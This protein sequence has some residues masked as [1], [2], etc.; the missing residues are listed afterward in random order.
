MQNSLILTVMVTP[1]INVMKYLKHEVAMGKP[2]GRSFVRGWT[3]TF[4]Y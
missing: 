2:S 4:L 3:V 1:T